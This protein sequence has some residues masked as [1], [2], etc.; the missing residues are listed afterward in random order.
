MD[1]LVDKIITCEFNELDN[2]IFP[3]NEQIGLKIKYNGTYFEF[4]LTIK[5]SNRLLILGSGA[6]TKQ[7]E[8]DKK[9]PWFNRWTWKFNE[10]TLYYN[11]PTTYVYPELTTGWGVG[12]KEQWFLEDISI[13]IKKISEKIS[14]NQNQMIF[15]GSSAGGF[16]S[17]LL[18]TLLKES[19]GIA[20]IPQLNLRDYGYQHW[21]LLKKNIFPD[22]TNEEILDKYGYRVDAITLFNKMNYIPKLYLILDCSV[23]RDFEYNYVPFF[24]RLNKLPYNDMQNNIKIRIDGKNKGHWAQDYLSTLNTLK[25][26]ISIENDEIQHDNNLSNLLEDLQQENQNLKYK[27]TVIKKNNINPQDTVEINEKLKNEIQDPQSKISLFDDNTQLLT[28]YLINEFEFENLNYCPI[29]NTISTFKDFG[30]PSRK[31]AQCPHCKSL[32]RHRLSYI[33]IRSRFNELLN[34][35][36]I[37][38][39]HFAPELTFYNIF[40]AMNNIDYYPVDINPNLYANMNLRDKVDMENIQYA[41]ETFDIIYNYNVLARVNNDFTAMSELYRILK[42]DGVCIVIVPLYNIPKTLEKKE[43][44]TPELRLKFYGQKNHMRKYGLDFKNRLETVGFNV[45]EVRKEHLIKSEDVQEF[46][47]LG[48]ETIYICTK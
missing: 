9:R 23:E 7:T 1:K 2:I 38:L 35:P 19:I 40:S 4:L 12:T 32:E 45:E 29:C 41:D 17:I 6:R 28:Q 24:N 26:I 47:K 31:N 42:K 5:D 16:T 36:Q 20:E 25:K 14:I 21:N 15:I 39:L 10:S 13:I 3:K 44:N 46:Y 18:S 34:K 30:K 33:L 27:L 11:D 22:M 37:K 48:W 8:V 43:Y